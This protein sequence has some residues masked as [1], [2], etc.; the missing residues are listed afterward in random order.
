M[1][2][3]AADRATTHSIAKVPAL[4]L[5]AGLLVLAGC[6]SSSEWL[7]LVD[8]DADQHARDAD[9]VHDVERDER[10]RTARGRR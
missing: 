1:S 10:W 5:I 8:V 2:F 7:E 4:A 6:G 3:N 9:N